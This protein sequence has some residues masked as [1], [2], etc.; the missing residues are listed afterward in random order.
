[1][2]QPIQS[3]DPLQKAIGL[4][5]QDQGLLENAFVH[6]SYLNEHRD[7]AKPSNEKLEF[8]GDSVLSLIT[9]VYLFRN[10]PALHEGDYTEI[11]AAIVKTA[12]LAAAARALHLGT[13]LLLSRGEERG[14]GRD[15][16]NLLADCFEALIA[17]IFLDQGFDAAFT[18][19]SDHLFT[20][21][22]DTIIQTNAY[23][24]HKSQLQEYVQ[25]KKK[26][27]PVYQ[28]IKEEGPEHDRTFTID[29]SVGKQIFGRGTGRSKK[30]AEEQAAQVALQAL[31]AQG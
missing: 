29:V 13:F 8:L 6:R 25:A 11:K 7:F 19:V 2:Y 28:T 20:D 3:Y 10:Y 21:T 22:L 12:S 18:F 1:M 5:L 31:R 26:M 30:E 27:T 24:S 23:H 16:T 14:G 9:S 15:N 4:T 17:V